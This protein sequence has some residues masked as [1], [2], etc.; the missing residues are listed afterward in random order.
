M[1]WW[2]YK[3]DYLWFTVELRKYTAI[4][5]YKSTV[6]EEVISSG[7]A[8][9]SAPYGFRYPLKLGTCP[10]IRIADLLSPRAI[11]VITRFSF[12]RT[13]VYPV[14]CFASRSRCRPEKSFPRRWVFRFSVHVQHIVFCVPLP[15]THRIRF[16]DFEFDV[17]PHCTWRVISSLLSLL[18]RCNHA[19]AALLDL[20]RPP[21]S[22]RGYG[23]KSQ[24]FRTRSLSIRIVSWLS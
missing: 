24:V 20:V 3:Y 15:P 14:L 16:T 4:P 12:I 1:S 9:G 8:Y 2:I 6:R 22:P 18:L 10:R 23:T 7:S 13:T 5:I 19:R 11:R 21:E 17:R